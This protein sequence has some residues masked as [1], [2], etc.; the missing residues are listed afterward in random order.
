MSLHGE[1]RFEGK[2]LYKLMKGLKDVG[3]STSGTTWALVGTASCSGLRIGDG[4]P[5]SAQPDKSDKLLS[6]RL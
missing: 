4:R 6:Y 5:V 1:A 2:M 3:S